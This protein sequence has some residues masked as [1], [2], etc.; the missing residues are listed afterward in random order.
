MRKSYDF[1][2]FFLIPA[3]TFCLAAGNS[4]TGTNFSVIGNREGRRAL[5]LLWG[6]VSGSYFYLYG[7]ELMEFGGCEDKTGRVC[8]FLSLSLFLCGIGLPY[9]PGKVPVLS[10]LHVWASFG[11]PVCLFFFL[12]RFLL[13]IEKKEGIRMAG[14]KLFQLATAAVSTFLY[15]RIGIVSSLLEMFVTLSTCVYLA[16]LQ[17]CLEKIRLSNH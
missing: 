15:L 13:L 17:G 16:V 1:F 7:R 12:Y 8:L 9:L 10:R 6:A 4:L 11:G 14:Q 5:F 3:L 2:S